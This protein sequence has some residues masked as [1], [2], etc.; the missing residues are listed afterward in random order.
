MDIILCFVSSNLE[1][2]QLTEL[3]PYEFSDFS[4]VAS[5]YL[6]YNYVSLINETAF[7]GLENLLQ[8]DLTQNELTEFPRLNESSVTTLILG[9]NRIQQ[10]EKRHFGGLM[11]L[12]HL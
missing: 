6:Q 12:T 3:R 7:N 8:I 4:E 11:K 9:Y 5:I 10:L 2:N 1:D